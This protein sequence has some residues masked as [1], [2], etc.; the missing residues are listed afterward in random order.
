[1]IVKFYKIIVN[2]EGNRVLK[3][4][5]KNYIFSENNLK[6]FQDRIFFDK[7]FGNYPVILDFKGLNCNNNQSFYIH[8]KSVYVKHLLAIS[9]C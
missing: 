7:H 9:I 5:M 6:I 4:E 3:N 2:K 8:L 1:M